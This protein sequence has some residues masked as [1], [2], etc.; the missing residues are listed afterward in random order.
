MLQKKLLN[1]IKN[2]LGNFCIEKWIA[3]II[4]FK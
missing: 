4:F 2:I 1:K 3:K